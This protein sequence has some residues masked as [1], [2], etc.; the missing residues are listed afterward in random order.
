MNRHIS[1]EQL[2][3]YLD[4]EMGFAEMRQL[5]A[6]CEACPECGA[7]LAS[8]RRVVTGLGRTDRVAL[9]ASLHQQI[10]RQIVQEIPAHGIRKVWQSLRFQF[11]PL[12]P[13]LR[14]AVA[15]G[16]AIVA[17]LFTLSHSLIGTVAPVPEPH[18]S[19]EKVTVK[20]GTQ[21][22]AMLKTTSK[23]AGRDFTW[24]NAGWV[25]DGLEGRT[26]EM[27]VDAR[28]PRGRELL[29]RYSEL[30]L[31]LFEGDPVVLTYNLQTVEIRV[32]PP[33]RAIGL[34]VSPPVKTQG[35]A[36]SA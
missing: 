20:A 4:S 33:T 35:R 15:M 8:M 1:T 3:A 9:P 19:Q 21:P 29:T 23:V 18:F 5:K 34:E 7:R 14:T 2:S 16:L 22:L 6:H 11:F 36:L 28:S 32:K 10:R 30:Q 27:S 24:T 26:P 13:G 17:G 31:L 25:Q 12:Q